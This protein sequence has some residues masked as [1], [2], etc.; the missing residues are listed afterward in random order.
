[1]NTARLGRGE[2]PPNF[3]RR[4]SARDQ[5]FDADLQRV[6]LDQ[7]AGPGIDDNLALDSPMNR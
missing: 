1:L 6:N 3:V 4:V 5:D 7:T 2:R